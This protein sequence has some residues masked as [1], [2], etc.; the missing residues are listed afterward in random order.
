VP[1]LRPGE[2]VSLHWDWVC[3]RL[4]A[5][6]ESELAGRTARQLDAVNGWLAGRLVRAG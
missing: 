6:Q 4:T 3:D 5:T 1:G 2:V